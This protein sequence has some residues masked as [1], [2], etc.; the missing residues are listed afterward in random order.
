ME[1]PKMLTVYKKRFETPLEALI[2]ARFEHGIPAEVPM[3]YAGRLDPMAVGQMIILVGDECKNRDQYLGRDKT[4]KLEILFGIGT[5]TQ[6]VF[7]V[8]DCEEEKKESCIREFNENESVAVMIAAKSEIMNFMGTHTFRYPKYSTKGLLNEENELPER[9]MTV[10]SIRTEGGKMISGTYIKALVKEACEKIKG[11][12]RYEE[13]AR[14]WEIVRDDVE[15]PVMKFEIECASGTYMRT[16]AQELG[17]RM[18]IPA[19]AYYIERTRT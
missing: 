15:Y 9:E 17:K 14:S 1:I 3:T 7:G 2:Q 18:G 19:L 13:I 4:Y 8:I 12:F 5:D 11:D 10:A 6:D 16:I